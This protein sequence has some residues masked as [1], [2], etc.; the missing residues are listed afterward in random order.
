MDR[1]T[2]LTLT[3]IAMATCAIV[4]LFSMRRQFLE[5]TEIRPYRV[6]WMFIALVAIATAVMLLVHLVNLF[7]FETGRR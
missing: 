2:D 5:K 7:G 6:P 1:S 4:A 3:L